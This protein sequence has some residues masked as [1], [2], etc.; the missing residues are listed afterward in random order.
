MSLILDDEAK[1]GKQFF[2]CLIIIVF[3][4][5]YAGKVE[6]FTLSNLE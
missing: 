5:N 1:L 6:V 2:I 3:I 4:Q